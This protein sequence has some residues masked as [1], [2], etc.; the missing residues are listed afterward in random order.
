K[1]IYHEIPKNA[2]PFQNIIDQTKP[3]IIYPYTNEKGFTVFYVCRW[4]YIDSSSGK[5]KK[6]ILPYV[7]GQHL[8]STDA[9]MSKWPDFK[10]PLYNLEEIIRCPEKPILIVEGE[11]TVEAAKHLFPNFIPTTSSGGSNAADKTDWS[12]LKGRTVYI[13]YDCD[14][15]GINYCEKVIDLLL[16]ENILQIYIIKTEKLGELQCN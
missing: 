7:Y 1:F 14:E 5:P 3:D 4:D 12:A 16:K 6:S 8:N 13:S 15:P 9:W 11:K 2:L 10:R